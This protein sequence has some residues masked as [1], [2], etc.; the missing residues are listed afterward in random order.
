MCGPRLSRSFIGMHPFILSAVT[1][2]LAEDRAETARRARRFPPPSPAPA[3]C[4]PP[5]RLPRPAPRTPRRLVSV[6]PGWNAAGTASIMGVVLR[7]LSSATFVGRADELAALDGALDRAAAGVPS[8]AFVAG[9]SGVGK[10]RL[11]VEFEARATVAGARVLIGHC[12]ELGGTVF[13]YAPL[14]D[15]L[16]PVARE[17]AESGSHLELP[18][19]TRAALAELMPEFGA[20]NEDFGFARRSPETP[21]GV[22]RATLHSQPRLFEALLSLLE[23]LGRD[24]PVALVLEDL[25]WADPSTRDFLVFLVRSARTEALCLLVTYRSDELHRRHPLRPVLA[26]CQRV[27]GVGR[28]AVE[29]FSRA[30]VADQLAGI[31]DGPADDELIERLYARGQGNPLYTEELLAASADGCTELPETLRDALLARFERLPAAAQEVVRV[32]A[33]VERPMGDALL[34]AISTLPEAELLQGAREAVADQVLGQPSDGTYAFRH[35]LVG[36]AIFED[37]LPGERTAMHAAFAEAIERDPALL[38]AT[39]PRR[40]SPPS[41]HATGAPRTTCRGR[42]GRRS[43]P[44]SPSGGVFAYSEALGT[45]NARSSCGPRAPDAAE[46]A[47]MPRADVLRE[48]ASAASRR[49]RGERAVALQREALADGA[50][51]RRPGAALADARRAGAPPATRGRARRERRRAAAGARPA[52]ARGRARAGGAARP[53]GQ[54]P[55]AA[56]SLPAGCRRGGGRRQGRPAPRRRHARD[57]RLQHRGLLTRRARRHRGRRSAPARGPRPRSRQRVAGRPRARRAQP[58]RDARPV[59]PH[60]GGA[61]RG[62]RNAPSD[63]ER[64]P[65]RRSTTRSSSSSRRTSCCGSAAPPRPPRRCRTG[66]RAT[67]SARPRCT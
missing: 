35:A 23:R 4:S 1:N 8:F 65:G 11:V 38:G 32:A 61:G 22:Q 29:R 47:G 49:V 34:V 40:R 14:V 46:R 59:R 3:R 52:S 30:E 56:G 33:V 55:D 7:R 12:L 54:G 51:G 24:R 53:E 9:E 15:A 5:L 39:C 57:G 41:W 31:L 25:H 20:R 62:A 43:R 19:E 67:R 27:P 6:L 28:I 50:E 45:S 16:R 63:L 2:Q 10:S 64:T 48:A 37:L 60:R 21:P 13:P 18:E 42:S 26:V 58:V 66:Y 44:A 17:M 36:E